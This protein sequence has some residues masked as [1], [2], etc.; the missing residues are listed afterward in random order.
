LETPHTTRGV[1]STALATHAL[2]IMGVLSFILLR[3]ARIFLGKFE[4]GEEKESPIRV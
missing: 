3:I 4:A 2:K 1:S